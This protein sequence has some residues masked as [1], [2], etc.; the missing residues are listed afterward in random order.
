[1]QQVTDTETRP[2]G[3]VV[4]RPRFWFEPRVRLA[5][6]L[7]LVVA[8]VNSANANSVARVHLCVRGIAGPRA[9]GP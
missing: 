3:V 2:G 7:E 5:P 6:T 4:D 8:V 9:A 1:M